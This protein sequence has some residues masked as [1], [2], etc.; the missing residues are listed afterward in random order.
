MGADVKARE[1]AA[2]LPTTHPTFPPALRLAAVQ[3]ARILVVAISAL[4]ATL[5]R[6]DRFGMAAARRGP[7]GLALLLLLLLAAAVLLLGGP[8][9][10]D[11]A[12]PGPAGRGAGAGHGACK[13]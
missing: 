13:V 1:Q 11:G 9:G 8:T 3:V 4:A 2:P 10:A 12:R 7:G 5:I 6:V